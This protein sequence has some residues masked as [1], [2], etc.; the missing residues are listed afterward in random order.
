M[1]LFEDTYSEN[2]R[3]SCEVRW[4]VSLPLA[5]RRK[6]LGLIEDARGKKVRKQLEAELIEIWTKKK[7]KNQ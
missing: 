6:V 4:L 7:S 2:Y 3:H 5:T 1:D